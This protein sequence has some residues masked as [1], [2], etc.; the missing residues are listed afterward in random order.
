M[1]NYLILV[2]SLLCLGLVIEELFTFGL[3]DDIIGPMDENF[4]TIIVSIISFL[5][6]FYLWK[7]DFFKKD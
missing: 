5:G 1:K 4:A 2:F 7:K 6:F 3:I